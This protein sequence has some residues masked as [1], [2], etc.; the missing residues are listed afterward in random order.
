MDNPRPRDYN[1]KASYRGPSTS[2]YLPITCIHAKR[3][4]PYALAGPGFY[5][6]GRN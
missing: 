1:L 4:D 2:F 3:T 6:R 5:L